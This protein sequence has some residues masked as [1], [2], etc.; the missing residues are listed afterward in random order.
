M[1]NTTK[2][3]IRRFVQKEALYIYIHENGSVMQYHTI[4]PSVYLDMVF[5]L[6]KITYSYKLKGIK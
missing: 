5:K 1:K 2:K 6:V 4:L 3:W